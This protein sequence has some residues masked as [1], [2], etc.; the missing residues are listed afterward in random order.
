MTSVFHR[1]DSQLGIKA[2]DV[3]TTPTATLGLR[4][5]GAG[6]DERRGLLG[7]R[8]LESRRDFENVESMEC[9]AKGEQPFRP[10]YI[11]QYVMTTTLTSCLIALLAL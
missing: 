8:D 7:L 6:E 11:I 2:A 5:A 1:S 10:I 9:L 4:H 3:A